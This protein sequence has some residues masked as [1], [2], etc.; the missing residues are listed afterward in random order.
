MESEALRD[1]VV[2]VGIGQMASVLSFGLLRSGRVVV[3]VTRERRL[4][5]VAEQCPRPALVMVAVGETELEGVLSELPA[6]WRDRVGLLQNELRPRAWAR[7][8]ITSPTVLSAWFEKKRGMDV[9]VLRPSPVFG[10]SAGMVA[11]ALASIGVDAVLGA[12]DELL[13][14]LAK[15]NLYILTVNIAGLA[16]DTT[17]GALWEEHRALVL[18][19]LDELLRLEA[20]RLETP[21]DPALQRASWT[22]AVAAAPDRRARGRTARE[23][24]DR[25]LSDADRMGLAVPKLREIESHL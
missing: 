4:A 20:A 9:R 17:V 21:L 6:T 5:Q 22:L 13:V 24:L 14:E 10:P 2:I 11:H 23:R 7:H 8:A 18:E 19:L 1:A 15:K 16:V 12:D 25:A 3:P